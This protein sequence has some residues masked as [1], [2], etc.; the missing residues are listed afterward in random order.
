MLLAT[1]MVARAYDLIVATPEGQM[2]YYTITSET[3]V[4]VVSGPTKPGGRLTI[5]S[6][7][8]GYSVTEIASQ[9]FSNDNGLTS[10]SIPGSVTTIGQ[11]AFVHCSALTSA[12]L[13]EGVQSIG[14]MA[15][16]SCTA[17]DTI[18]LPST[19]TQIAMGAFGNTAYLNDLGHWQDSVLYVGR[20]LVSG[21]MRHGGEYVVADSTLGIANDAL[22]TRN[23]NRFV[24]PA[25]LH[26]IG[27]TA[28]RGCTQLDTVRLLGA[29]PP[30]LGDDAFQGTPATLTVAVP[31]GSAETYSAAQGWSQITI[32]ED[33]CSE[34]HVGIVA[35]QHSGVTAYVSAGVLHIGGAEGDPLTV[36][37]ITGRRL[38]S[39][40]SAGNSISVALPSTG[41]YIVSVGTSMPLKVC[42]SR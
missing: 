31:C 15:F 30:V 18:S 10:V 11:R 3:T 28:F 37:D 39:T 32:V 13:G 14:L 23:I 26:F 16:S 33:T 9:A 5:P 34:P 7:V 8:Q 36:C 42:Y 24:L 29:T 22:A 27:A 2:L 21:M 17:L 25:S 4:K 35:S 38:Y 20:Y 1:V 41:V 40:R 6:E 12:F 19:L